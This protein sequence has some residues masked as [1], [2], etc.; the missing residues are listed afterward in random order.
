MLHRHVGLLDPHR[1]HAVGHV[2]AKVLDRLELGVRLGELVVEVGKDGFLD[3]LD[4]DRELQRLFFFG[5]RVVGRE[6]DLVAGGG[7]PE[8]LVDLGHDGARTEE[9]VV[10]RGGETGDGFVA[11]ACLD[12]DRDVI[13]VSGSPLDS[14]QFGEVAAQVVDLLVDLFVAGDGVRDL[15]PQTVVAGSADG[16]PDLDDGVELHGAVLLA[17]GDF[18]L[19]WSDDVDV[20]LD[21]SLGV[22]LGHRLAQGL[23]AADCATELR[24]EQATG[25][26]AG[27]EA[28]HA[29]LFRN[30]LERSVD[31]DVECFFVDFNRE[32]HPVVVEGLHSAL[33][34]GA[35]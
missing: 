15:D 32:L 7:A 33:H 19:R 35:A 9:V 26:L 12:I 23:F 22:V 14:G 31:G 4:G 8:V 6:L 30:A 5:I 2:G 18:D 24:L 16:G 20:V 11:V 10:V 28:R 27:T 1:V 21:H 3:L 17:A 34:Q 13:F 25:R 29:D